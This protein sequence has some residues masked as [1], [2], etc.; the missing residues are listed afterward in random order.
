MKGP[1]DTSLAYKY[2]MSYRLLDGQRYDETVVPYKQTR[3]YR[4]QLK[5]LMKS[6]QKLRIFFS[7]ITTAIAALMFLPQFSTIAGSLLLLFFIA[8]IA[9]PIGF[10]LHSWK[11]PTHVGIGPKGVRIYTLHWYGD[12]VSKP[13]PWS[14]IE[15]ATLKREASFAGQ[16]DWIELRENDDPSNVALHLALDGIAVGDN[17]K[18]F[19]AALKQH[20]SI[21]QIDLALQDALNPVKLGSHT[22]MWLDVLSNSP[23]RLIE[24]HLGKGNLICNGR[25]RVTDQLGIGG[26]AVAYIAEQLT[27]DQR[28]IKTVV[29]KEFVLPAEASLRISK[30]AFEAIEQEAELL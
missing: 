10:L 23:K 4:R 11:T 2:F 22:E 13:I 24:S 7:I 1:L 5:Q 6:Q 15:M 14:K 3:V 19:L 20:L 29:L 21:N 25:Y 16:T 12:N 26:Q 28:I 18:R 17:R 9:L 30:R 27:E 8:G